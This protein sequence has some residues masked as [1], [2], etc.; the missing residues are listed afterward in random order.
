MLRRLQY[1]VKTK[2]FSAVNSNM[3]EKMMFTIKASLIVVGLIPKV[4]K[5]YMLFYFFDIEQFAC[6]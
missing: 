4:Y 1:D 5:S 3:G 2:D 6:G